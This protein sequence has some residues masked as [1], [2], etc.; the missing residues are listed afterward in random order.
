MP[1]EALTGSAPVLTRAMPVGLAPEHHVILGLV[2]PGAR[3]LDLGCGTGE[4][5]SALMA[6]RGVRAEGIELAPEC[7]QACVARGLRNVH[8]AD[9]DEGL[10]DYADQSVDYVILTSTIQVLQRPLNL[11]R[12]M[13][14]V[15]KRCIIGFPNFGHWRCRLQLLL[16]GRMPKTPL[17]PYE[18]HDTPNIHL[19]TIR[20]FRD[21]ARSAG[22]GVE[23]EIALLTGAQR[24]RVVCAGAN[25][26]ADYA[27]FVVAGAGRGE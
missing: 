17:L 11:I 9:L 1:K 15:G 19:T 21:F 26:W 2:E 6:V 5:L 14:R 7:I 16:A 3:V 22:L 23:E 4:L 24:P 20:D 27:V 10:A 8:Q 25:L 18:W 12:E 13:A